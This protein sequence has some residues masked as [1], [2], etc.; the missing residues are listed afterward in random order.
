MDTLEDTLDGPLK[1]W[2]ATQVVIH[3]DTFGEILQTR[4][5]NNLLFIHKSKSIKR[6]SG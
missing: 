3:T 1:Y 5:L 6:F 2:E 4:Q